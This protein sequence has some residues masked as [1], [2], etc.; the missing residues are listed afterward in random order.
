MSNKKRVSSIEVARQAGVS[1]SAVSRAFTPGASLSEEKRK[2]I[3]A[4]AA[5]LNYTPN[6]IARSLVKSSTRIIGIV[7]D[8]FLS[9]FYTT[10]LN[11]FT[12]L[13][14]QQGYSAL[15]LNVHNDEEVFAGL[16]T[17]LQ[18]QVDGLIVTSAN[19]D[20]VLVDSCLR[21]EHTPIV[22]FN[23]YQDH[24]GGNAVFCNGVESGRMVADF[25]FPHH[26]RFGCIQGEVTS[27]T[28][29]DRS[30][31][32]INRL[33]EL[34]VERCLSVNAEFSYGS[35]YQAAQR[36]LA[37]NERPDAIFCVSDIMALGVM[38]AARKIYGLRIP[39][40]LAVVGF[41]DIPMA[42]WHAYDL[43]TV[44]QPAEEMAKETVQLL[45]R[46][47]EGTLTRAMKIQIGTEIVVRTSTRK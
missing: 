32:F 18:Y 44:V 1:Q 30:S 42:S 4:V 9:P 24:P 5:Q 40:D 22:F 8:R 28:S 19:L 13:I 33:K 46:A 7:M 3:H 6:V 31:G 14:Q 2:H 20:S 12:R 26:T 38:D 34:G 21:E 43:T 47:I 25:L 41:D 17:A 23:R 11:D 16:S 37:E 45:L 27:S 36:L 35:G 39:E 15:L 10:V 29:R